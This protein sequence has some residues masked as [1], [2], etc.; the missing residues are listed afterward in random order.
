MTR[1]TSVVWPEH[2]LGTPVRLLEYDQ[3]EPLGSKRE[4]GTHSLV[5]CVDAVVGIANAPVSE[6]RFELSS[7]TWTAIGALP[8]VE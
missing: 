5:R 4:K 2:E 8:Y 3:C 1:E 6:H 7:D